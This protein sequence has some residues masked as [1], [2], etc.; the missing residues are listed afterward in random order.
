[1]AELDSPPPALLD[2]AALFLDF[3]GT[4]VELAETPG[5]VRVPSALGRLLR[6]LCDRLD[7]RLAIVSG[8]SLGDLKR[9]VPFAGIA[10]SGSHGLELQWADGSHLPLSVPLGLDEV[11]EKVIAFA[12]ASRG[13]L[14]EE[15]PAG[16]ALHYRLAPDEGAHAEAFMTALAKER[17][18]SVQ[19]GAM[20]IEL[21]PEGATKGDA[22]RAFMSEPDFAGARP[23]FV[24][25]DLTDEHAFAAAAALDGAGVLVGPQRETA[26]AY[27]LDSVAAVAGWLDGWA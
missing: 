2:G 18:F 27:R 20:V 11:R 4:L 8:R 19:R 5:A 12:A 13:L 6:R 15:K 17:G 22:L 24:G 23:V 21:R 25:D 3:D 1:M 7:G 26:A 10:F 9:H 16:I 14:V